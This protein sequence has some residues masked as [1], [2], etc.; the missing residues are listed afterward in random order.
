MEKPAARGGRCGG[1]SQVAHRDCK[2]HAAVCIAQCCDRTGGLDPSQWAGRPI[3]TTG[4]NPVLRAENAFPPTGAARMITPPSMSTAESQVIGLIGLAVAWD[5]LA[6]VL[7]ALL[8]GL[9]VGTALRFRSA[10]HQ[11]AAIE[12]SKRERASLRR[13]A[14]ELAQTSDVE[15][16]ARALLDEIGSLFRVDFAALSFISEDGREASGYLARSDGN[17]VEWWQDVHMDLERELS[18]IASA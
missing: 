16:V 5:R 18:G 14:S 17:D 3:F 11:R 10:R 7:G 1:L 4:E 9:V 15:G 6:A 8:V 2:T 13:V 12:E